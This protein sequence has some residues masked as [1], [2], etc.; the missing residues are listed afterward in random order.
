MNTVL[1]DEQKQEV[2]TEVLTDEIRKNV[3][4]TLFALGHTSTS[5]EMIEHLTDYA[6]KRK[7][8]FFSIDKIVL[9]ALVECEYTAAYC[10]YETR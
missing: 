4:N 6:M 5:D 1:T 9:N 10:G 7:Q 2:F 8:M 3:C